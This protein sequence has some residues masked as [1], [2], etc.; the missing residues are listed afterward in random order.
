M[1]HEVGVESLS[2]FLA[3]ELALD[4]RARVAAH[5]RSC[6][7]CGRQLDLLRRSASTLARPQFSRRARATALGA[8]LTFAALLCAGLALM[9]R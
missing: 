5:V 6:A 2:A 7:E 1:P 8:A 4:E 3:G 9:R